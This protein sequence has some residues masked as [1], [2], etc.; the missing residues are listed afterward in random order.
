MEEKTI[1][2]GDGMEMELEREKELDYGD[3]MVATAGGDGFPP[4][5]NSD[6]EKAKIESYDIEKF[7]R[8]FPTHGDVG[9]RLRVISRDSYMRYSVDPSTMTMVVRGDQRLDDYDVSPDRYVTLVNDI[10]AHINEK[11]L[12]LP[13]FYEYDKDVVDKFKKEFDEYINTHYV[14]PNIDFSD[15]KN[16]FDKSE[17]DEILNDGNKVAAVDDLDNKEYVIK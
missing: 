11:E 5:K 7:I 13:I 17:L 9:V 14:K 6:Y 16:P 15:V 10:I 4:E 12:L 2:T 8:I 3:V 1:V